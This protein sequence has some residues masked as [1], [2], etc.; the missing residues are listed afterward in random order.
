MSYS[1]QWFAFGVLMFVGFGYAARQQ[2]RN[3]AIDAEEEEE[4]LP[5]GAVHSAVPASRRRPDPPR[6]RTR[7]TAEEEEDARLDAQF[8]EKQVRD[9][10]ADFNARVVD[11]RRQL[12]GGPPVITKTRDVEAEVALWRER[13]AARAA[14]VAPPEPEPQRPWWR[15]LW[16]PR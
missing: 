12:Q 1:L 16:N 7:A 11:A 2:A 5:D 10:L 3:A 15:R 13:Q 14:V 6:K 4:A 9:I 8:T